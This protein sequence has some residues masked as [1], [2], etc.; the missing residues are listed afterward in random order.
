MTFMQYNL[1]CEIESGVGIE[2]LTF[3]LEIEEPN[4]LANII[5]SGL[6]NSKPSDTQNWLASYAL[7]SLTH[8][9]QIQATRMYPN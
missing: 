1:S 3:E 6:N 4:P 7:M 9:N 8:C 5:F 2:P